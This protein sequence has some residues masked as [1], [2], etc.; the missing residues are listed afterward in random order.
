MGRLTERDDQGR[1]RIKSN[2]FHRTSTTRPQNL[3]DSSLKTSVLRETGPTD[4][5]RNALAG[6]KDEK[7]NFGTDNFYR[8]R[9]TVDEKESN[10][11]F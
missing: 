10:F 2:S 5:I 7:R 6:N 8:R 11:K 3:F 9:Y 4:A 1:Y